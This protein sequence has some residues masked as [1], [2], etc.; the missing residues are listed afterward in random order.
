[1]WKKIVCLF[2]CAA[3]VP[4][5]AFSADGDLAQ[6]VS[7]LE[8]RV[9]QGWFD[10]I[11]LSGAVEAEANYTSSD[12]ENSSDIDLTTVELGVDVALTKN[13]SGFVLAKWED[14]EG[15]L[16]IDEGGIVLGNVEENGLALTVGKLYVPFGVFESNFI[17]DPLTLEL[18]ETREGAAVVDFSAQ[19]LYGAAYLFNSELNKAGSDDKIDA[20]GAKLGYALES[21]NLSFDVSAGY[22]SN[23]TSSGGF[24]DGLGGGTEIADQSAGATVS[25]IVSIADFTFVGEYMA[26]LDSDYSET[27]NSEPTALQLEVSY[28]FD[29][30][31]HESSV[32]ATYQQTDEASDLGLAETRYGVVFAYEIVEGLGTTVEYVR[33]ESYDDDDEEDSL[34]C[35]LALEF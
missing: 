4:A 16:F 1:M 9:G 30:L 31:E 5:L 15:A 27:N 26:V 21:D 2:L 35:Q 23:I 22:I 11:E 32:A 7:Q 33:N 14:D 20:Y 19:G 18:G 6:R 13:F 34:T 12:D 17:S 29:L 25:A 3:F 10:R 8:E 24:V 28:G